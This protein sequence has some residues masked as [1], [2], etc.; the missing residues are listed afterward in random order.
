M[1]MKK[2]ALKTASFLAA[3]ALLTALPLSI[4]DA[5]YNADTFTA[6]ADETEGDLRY[7][8]DDDHVVITGCS[9]N[10][11]D[12]KI[13]ESIGGKPV[14]AIDD[15]AFDAA[16]IT[17][18]TIPDSVK[19]IGNWSFSLCTELKSLTIPDSVEYIGIRA[20]E[21]NSSLKLNSSI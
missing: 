7:I 9:E 16:S 11:T 4:P 12:I 10:A 8:V 20:F 19:T 5:A 13:P 15:Y 14:T 21:M 18:V 6:Y 3:A 1:K 2:M 17:S